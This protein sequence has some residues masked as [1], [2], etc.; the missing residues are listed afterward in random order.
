MQIIMK[1]DD[2]GKAMD[3]LAVEFTFRDG[4]QPAP[5]KT[6][7][8]MKEVLRARLVQLMKLGRRDIVRKILASRGAV[9]VD[10]LSPEHYESC[11]AEA[12]AACFV[13]ENNYDN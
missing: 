3:M 1:L 6:E 12:V 10:E 2:K 7:D 13:E 4:R 5:R 9:A 11:Y 8:L